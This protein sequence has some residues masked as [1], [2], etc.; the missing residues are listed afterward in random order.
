MLLLSNNS[1]NILNI[2]SEISNKLT[3]I[4]NQNFFQYLGFNGNILIKEFET[5]SEYDLRI[6]L[7][8]MKSTR[9]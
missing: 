3:C 4:Y 2:D 8:F 5:K 1:F 6:Q 9:R 7:K